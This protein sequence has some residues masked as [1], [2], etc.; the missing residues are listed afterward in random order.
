M[1]DKP[2]AAELQKAAAEIQ[3]QDSKKNEPK[4]E[5]PKI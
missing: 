4:K 3:N 5:E 2:T 1:K